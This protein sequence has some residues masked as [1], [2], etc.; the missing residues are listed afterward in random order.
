MGGLMGDN[1][2]D[3]EAV[4]KCKTVVSLI[5]VLLV[6]TAGPIWAL[7]TPELRAAYE[8]YRRADY[9]RAI[10]LWEDALNKTNLDDEDK[11]Q[12]HLNIALSYN[13]LGKPQLAQRH[14]EISLRFNPNDPNAYVAQGDLMAAQGKFKQAV[15]NYTNAIALD[16]EFFGAYLNR[17]IAHSKSRNLNAAL[18][19]F[20][21]AMNY[22]APPP[23]VYN[24]RGNAYEYMGSLEQALAQFTRAIEL[25][26]TYPS[27]YFNR[28][29]I[30]ERM[31][32][33]KEGMAD[34][35]RFAELAPGHPWARIRIEQ[36]QQKLE[37]ATA[38][39]P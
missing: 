22:G 38:T 15:A 20:D 37:A 31:G 12:I 8:A 23:Q 13:A 29:R 11:G 28:S 1:S 7:D 27:P 14:M 16:S 6:L 4:M 24:A 33:L 10:S 18:A 2:P 5:L 26:P 39:K 32:R 21:Q 34:A 30:Y 25:K 3:K 9:P 36:L 17:A 35:K 19:D